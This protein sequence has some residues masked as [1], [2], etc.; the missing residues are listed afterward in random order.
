MRHLQRQAPPKK[1]S[2]SGSQPMDKGWTQQDLKRCLPR[3]WPKERGGKPLQKVYRAMSRGYSDL[4]YQFHHAM[5]EPDYSDEMR[6]CVAVAVT[7]GSKER[8]P[9]FHTSKSISKSRKYAKLG[10]NYRGEDPDAQLFCCLHIYEMFCDDVLKPGDVIDLSDTDAVTAFFDK[11]PGD[12]GA[13][14]EE[15]FYK[16][17]NYAM[18]SEEV[19]I[20][21]RGCLDLQYFSVVDDVTGK[22]YGPL[23]EYV[24]ADKLPGLQPRQPASAPP[25]TENSKPIPPWRQRP[26]EAAEKLPDVQPM[27]PALPPPATVSSESVP[28][29]RKKTPETDKPL[30]P[31]MPARQT[32]YLEPV[33]AGRS[34]KRKA[35]SQEPAEEVQGTQA[36]KDEDP[37]TSFPTPDG[38][39]MVDLDSDE[40]ETMEAGCHQDDSLPVVESLGDATSEARSQSDEHVPQEHQLH[41]EDSDFL[42]IQI[43]SKRR[44]SVARRHVPM[45]NNLVKLEH[46]YGAELQRQHEAWR[47]ESRA[48][49]QTGGRSHLCVGGGYS[50]DRQLERHALKRD[51]AWSDVSATYAEDEEAARKRHK[52]R[53]SNL[54]EEFGAA[55]PDDHF[56]TDIPLN[57]HSK[58]CLQEVMDER[59]SETNE[60]NY[61]KRL[62]QMGLLSLPPGQKGRKASTTARETPLTESERSP[63]QDWRAFWLKTGGFSSCTDKDKNGWTALH[64]A[65]D[66]MTCSARAMHAAK[67]LAMC[68]P[69]SVLDAA[70]TGEQ[71]QG[72]TAL[73]LACDGSDTNLQKLA[74][75]KTLLE[76]KVNLEA[77]DTKGN[78]PLLLAAGTGLTAVCETLLDYGAD[79]YVKNINDQ[80]AYQKAYFSSR[81]LATVLFNR[82]C[83]CTFSEKKGR[84]RTG[85]GESRRL[86]ETMTTSATSGYTS[87]SARKSYEQGHRW[88]EW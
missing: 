50:Y 1:A 4:S 44:E 82:G 65:I 38:V 51:A 69:Y 3:F 36:E 86:R 70:T 80:G 56:V 14:F 52:V 76:R 25:A 45:L 63:F 83:P 37:D 23:L 62:E 19:L 27:T 13:W 67:S 55:F 31:A 57:Q 47:R 58:D 26:N 16:C 78:T 32:P 49:I 11:K 17:C 59:T 81:E 39:I 9:F 34:R 84:T 85:K 30:M 77:R 66:T 79:K 5:R 61:T 18:R 73:H 12:Y 48:D 35:G 33:D 7:H 40:D 41:P 87:K 75:V 21:W 88:K 46:L 71:P 28:P 2:A 29:W 53:L 20:K 42:F 72:C 10:A 8:S 24:P 6:K 64:H 43:K 68:T 22:D 54:A 15:N 74:I 60:V